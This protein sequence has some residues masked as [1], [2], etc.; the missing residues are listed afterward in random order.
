M[1]RKRK[2]VKYNGRKEKRRDERVIVK[3]MGK[4][5]KEDEEKE[6]ERETNK[7]GR[8]WKENMK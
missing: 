6:P 3:G 7:L 1:E 5:G 8:S 4:Q 2:L